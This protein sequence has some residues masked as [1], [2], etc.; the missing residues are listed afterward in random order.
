MLDIGWVFQNELDFR[1][2][3]VSLSKSPHLSVY[4]TDLVLALV[5]IFG[6]KYITAILIRCFVPYLVY[7]GFTICFYSIFTSAGINSFSDEEQLIASFMGI[8]IICLDMY[9]LFFECV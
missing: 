3:I 6:E 4:K 1:E 7:F 9:F 2:L 5:E 8:V